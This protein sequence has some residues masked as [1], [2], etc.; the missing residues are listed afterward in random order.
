MTNY[1]PG[2]TPPT[3]TPLAPT[4][5]PAPGRRVWPFVAAIA[6]LAVALAGVLIWPHLN[7][8]K[9]A[10]PVASAAPAAA[11][12]FSVT[13]T[14][15]LRAGQFITV[16]S[17]GCRGQDGYD[18]IEMGASVTIT[19]ANGTVVGV[20]QINSLNNDGGMA[21]TCDLSFQ[22]DG[23]PAG[24]GFYGVEVSHRG[25]VKEPEAELK[26]GSVQLTIG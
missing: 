4:P 15:S 12:T 6:V 8:D 5:P 24:K 10:K 2:P 26:A 3:F 1:V 25:S 14:V 23:V 22:V 21:G 18:D 20:G 9:P 11:A 17:N 16:E 7:S 19:D 13:G